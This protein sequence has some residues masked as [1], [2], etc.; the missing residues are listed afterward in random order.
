MK[1]PLFIAFVSLL[2]TQAFAQG[3]FPG[4]K[5]VLS[6]AEWKRAG[7]NRLTPDEIGVIDAALIRHHALATKHYEAELNANRTAPAAPTAGAERRHSLLERFGLPTFDGPD[8]KDL[9]P[10][11]AKVTEWVSA[12]RFKLDNGQIW[13]GFA[14]IPFELVGKTVEIRARP[15]GQFVLAVDGKSTTVHVMRLR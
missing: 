12:N 5:E 2:G 10:L 9:P 13:E 3:S 8:W 6:D 14:A 7:L 15:R 11:H 4:L 1:F